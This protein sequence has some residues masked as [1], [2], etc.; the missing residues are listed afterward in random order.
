MIHTPM[1]PQLSGSF[2]SGLIS[3]ESGTWD[4][5][6]LTDIFLS[7]DVIRIM[8]IPISP[9]YD[10]SWYWFG[11]PR[12]CYSVKNGYRAIVGDYTNPHN[13]FD[14]W[15]LMWKLKVPL[16]WKLF[17]WRALN[18]ILPV[19]TNLI[20]KR[21]E[22]EPACPVCANVH[23]HVLLLCDFSQLVWHESLLPIT[24]FGA[25]SFHEWYT[26]TWSILTTDQL[27][28]TVALL[29]HIWRGRNNAVWNGFL[30]TPKK[31]VA[32]AL[33]TL[34]AWQAANCGNQSSSTLPPPANVASQQLAEGFPDRHKCFF[35]A[36]YN[37]TS[38]KATFGAV[39]MSSTGNFVAA[40]A[41][42][43]HDSFSPLMAETIACKEVLSWLKG[44]EVLAVDVHTDCMQLCSGLNSSLSPYYSYAG[45]FLDDCRR[46]ASDFMSCRYD[47]RR[48][49]S[50]FMSCRFCFT[51]R[52]QNVIAHSLAS[53]AVSQASTLYW[54]SVPPVSQASTLYW[55][56]VPP[57][58]IISFL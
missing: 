45:L 48:L 55:D 28:M 2:V 27:C 57:D 41:G 3:E 14:Q 8:K 50:D 54:D 30:P 33:T 32:A 10:D 38:H 29:Y 24:N 36:G 56:S 5:S 4:H 46:L 42:P 31:V 40:C 58:S 47:C 25:N 1:P 7:N 37:P 49:A 34:H 20:L 44:R 11:D 15:N 13:S 17:L 23:M 51:P 16:K 26:S 52:S 18:N 39:L 21:V 43:L 19:T 6:I 22:V 9:N 35:N 12:G 53:A